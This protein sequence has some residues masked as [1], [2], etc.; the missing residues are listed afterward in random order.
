MSYPKGSLLYFNILICDAA[1]QRKRTLVQV[2]TKIF[3]D[4]LSAPVQDLTHKNSHSVPIPKIRG[5]TDLVLHLPAFWQAHVLSYPLRRRDSLCSST[6]A[7]KK[8]C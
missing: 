8:K 4:G 5:R 2:P 6:I 3:A 7:D 1:F